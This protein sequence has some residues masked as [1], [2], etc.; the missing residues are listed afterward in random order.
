MAIVNKDEPAPVIVASPTQTPDDPVAD[1]EVVEDS[2]DVIEDEFSLMAMKLLGV[3]IL[4]FSV[5]EL[6]VGAAAYGALY[7]VKYGGWWIGILSFPA[8][9]GALLA[10]KR[11][12]VTA[13]VVAA[14]LAAILAFV[15]TVY[16]G[17]GASLMHTFVTC[18]GYGDQ[19]KILEASYCANNNFY[20]SSYTYSNLRKI[21]EWCSCIPKNGKSCYTYYVSYPQGSVESCN[22]LLTSYPMLLDASTV[23]SFLLLITTIGLSTVGIMILTCPAGYMG[24]EKKTEEVPDNNAVPPDNGLVGVNGNSDAV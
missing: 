24:G 1:G 19:S 9:V 21:S 20:S 5:I 22:D 2:E 7:N 8:G 18:G 15:S 12:W 16:D 4:V 13:T 3:V 17:L 23:F 10:N 14:I 6:G 11:I